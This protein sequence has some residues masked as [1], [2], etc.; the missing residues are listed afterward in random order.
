MRRRYRENKGERQKTGDDIERFEMTTVCATAEQTSDEKCDVVGTNVAS[1]SNQQTAYTKLPDNYDIELDFVVRQYTSNITNETLDSYYDYGK[2]EWKGLQKACQNLYRCDISGIRDFGNRKLLEVHWVVSSIDHCVNERQVSELVSMC[3]PSNK[4]KFDIS[5][6]DCERLMSLSERIFSSHLQK[7]QLH[8]Q[9]KTS[10]DY[11][12]HTICAKIPMERNCVTYDY[13]RWLIES[14]TASDNQEPN[15]VSR[16]T[17]STDTA[18]W[19]DAT[20]KAINLLYKLEKCSFAERDNS[21]AIIENLRVPAQYSAP[22]NQ[23]LRV[24]RIFAY[25]LQ[26]N[27]KELP[28]PDGVKYSQRPFPIVGSIGIEALIKEIVKNVN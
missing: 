1:S 22:W 23:I 17:D 26:V 19:K 7:W 15:V 18:S 28:N 8:A 13:F 21:L 20:Q 14:D 4:S 2:I 9:G 5:E 3:V 10:K 6:V 16:I 11:L 25:E 12:C 27:T 24:W